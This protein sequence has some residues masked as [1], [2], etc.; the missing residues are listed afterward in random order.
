MNKS[1]NL[2]KIATVWKIQI[3]RSF[4]S[5]VN[6][7]Q[8]FYNIATLW[9]G[10]YSKTLFYNRPELIFYAN[11]HIYK[12]Q[13]QTLD[14]GDIA[15]SVTL[16]SHQDNLFDVDVLHMVAIL[17]WTMPSHRVVTPKYPQYSD[18]SSR[19]NTF[20]TGWP[21]TIASS[22]MSAAGFFYTGINAERTISYGADAYI[23]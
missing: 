9:S 13:N 2:L 8:H 21:N 6:K 7:S 11:K 3:V 4:Q 1:Q 14:A 20:K 10:K 19:L 16:L 23:N 12:C 22:L 18:V 5:Y 15:S 17:N